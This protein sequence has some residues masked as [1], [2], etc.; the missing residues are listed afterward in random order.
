MINM[1]LLSLDVDARLN[2]KYIRET[3]YRPRELE[4]EPDGV[5]KARQGGARTE[6]NHVLAENGR[7]D[8]AVCAR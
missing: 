4:R 8:V 2:D 3:T 5:G 6:V 1:C 7:H